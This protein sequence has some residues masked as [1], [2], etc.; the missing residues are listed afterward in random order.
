MPII[1][2]CSK[3]IKNMQMCFKKIASYGFS[4]FLR[5][6]TYRGAYTDF[7]KFSIYPKDKNIYK[8]RFIIYLNCD[9][10]GL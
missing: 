6:C 8:E 3:K 1:V 5:K 9:H 4:E 2:M 7:S 10:Y